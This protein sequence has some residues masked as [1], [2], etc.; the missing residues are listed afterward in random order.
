[1]NFGPRAAFF[2]RLRMPRLAEARVAIAMDDEV[3]ARRLEEL[4][5]SVRISFLR[6]TKIVMPS[7]WVSVGRRKLNEELEMESSLSF[8][9]QS[10]HLYPS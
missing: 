10:W 1:M 5:V 7:A 3:E 4:N 9:L 8:R 6:A 2:Q